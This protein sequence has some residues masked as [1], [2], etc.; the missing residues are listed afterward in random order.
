MGGYRRGLVSRGD[1]GA[2]H[3]MQGN[4]DVIGSERVLHSSFP[5]KQTDSYISG[6]CLRR[7]RFLAP[8]SQHHAGR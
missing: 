7:G 1:S 6:W 4:V 8:L 2:A 3:L 5:S